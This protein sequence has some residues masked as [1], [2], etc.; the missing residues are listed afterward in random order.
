MNSL[1]DSVIWHP[2]IHDGRT[3]ELCYY[4]FKV[5]PSYDKETV[6]DAITKECKVHQIRSY[7]IYEVFGS[8][9][10]IFRAWIPKIETNKFAAKVKSWDDHITN[11]LSMKSIEKMTVK[12]TLHHWL[13]PNGSD[14][15]SEAIKLLDNEFE[16]NQADFKNIDK[17]GKLNLL[18]KRDPVEEGIRF[19][20]ILSGRD[21]GT[22][23]EAEELIPTIISTVIDNGQIDVINPELYYS[24]GISWFLI[25]SR[26]KFVDYSDIAELQKEINIAVRNIG[27][28]TSTFLCTQNLIN[29]REVDG[30]SVLAIDSPKEIPKIR[31]LLEENE[32]RLLEIKGS[33]R[34]NVGNYF[35]TN[36]TNPD[37]RMEHEILSAIVAFLNTNGGSLV[38]GALEPDRIPRIALNRIGTELPLFGIY[39]LIGINIDFKS[40]DKFKL[41]LLNIIRE[42]VIPF[43]EIHVTITFETIS[44]KVICLVSITRSDSWHYLKG[45]NKQVEFYIREDGSS[46]PLNAQQQAQYQ[47]RFPREKK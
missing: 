36:N 13:W 35:A 1:E 30:I 18:Q 22:M 28:R 32:S 39:C 25:D 33:L 29:T 47:K 37:Q 9:D 31:N 23:S 2:L 43:S 17:W 34:V 14:P 38:I 21:L 40:T 24:D 3:E 27:S 5:N 7:G 12:S 19:I 20:M 16:N 10:L 8:V 4:L 45:K 42:N 6:F 15:T 44:G 46:I 26:V 11:G 41:H